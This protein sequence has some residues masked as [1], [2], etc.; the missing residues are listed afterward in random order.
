MLHFLS[1]EF[2]SRSN[3]L[4]I[5]IVRVGFTPVNTEKLK[6]GDFHQP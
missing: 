3:M 6:K 2:A 4:F 5:W 1:K